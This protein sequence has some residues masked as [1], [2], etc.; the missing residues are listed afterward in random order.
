MQASTR[1]AFSRSHALEGLVI[2][3]REG[4]KKVKIKKYFFSWNPD[5]TGL[6]IVIKSFQF[7]PFWP[8][9]LWFKAAFKFGFLVEIWVKCEPVGRY[10]D[11]LVS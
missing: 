3:I 7:W 11:I 8:K 9:L 2:Q 10:I 1:E 4:S 5:L 6:M